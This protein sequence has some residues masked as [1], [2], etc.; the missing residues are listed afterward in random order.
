MDPV[1]APPSR[2]GLVSFIAWMGIIGGGLGLLASLAVLAR[3]TLAGVAFLLGAA[4]S[5]VTS[6]GLRARREWARSGFIYVLVY[7]TLMGFVAALR[8]H[9]PQLASFSQSAGTAPPLTQEQLDSMASQMRPIL[10]GAAIA[11]AVINGLLL[12]YFSSRKIRRE[13]D[14]ESAV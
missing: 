4:S 5:L 7:T 3:P 8:F 10:L 11:G 12:A 9:M 6:L 2:S 1:A 13:F 14:P